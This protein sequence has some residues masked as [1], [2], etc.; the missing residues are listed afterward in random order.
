MYASICIT[1]ISCL[2]CRNLDHPSNELSK[3]LIKIQEIFQSVSLQL[4]M[5]KIDYTSRMLCYSTPLSEDITLRFE[6][7]LQEN[8][9]T[10]AEKIQTDVCTLPKWNPWEDIRGKSRDIFVW[11]SFEPSFGFNSHVEYWNVVSLS[12]KVYFFSTNIK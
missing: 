12:P 3:M 8:K 11:K 6:T 10:V 4:L 1:T 2:R 9:Y 7:L 5:K